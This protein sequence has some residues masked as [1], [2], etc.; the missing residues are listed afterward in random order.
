MV[1]EG[2][3]RLWGSC[4]RS[5]EAVGGCGRA[6]P[7]F[8][9]PEWFWGYTVGVHLLPVRVGLLCTP[10]SEGSRQNG[11]PSA[12]A[13]VFGPQ[14]RLPRRPA[15]QPSPNPRRPGL[16]A[17]GGVPPV[18]IVRLLEY[19]CRRC[20]QLAAWLVLGMMLIT[21]LVVFL[22]Y[23][24][25]TGSIALQESI[26]FLH[27][28]FFMLG[29]A[30]ALQQDAHVRVDIFYRRFSPLGRSLVNCAGHLFF[31]FPFCL[32]IL[33]TS[34]EYMTV[35]WAIRER[36][37]EAGGLGYV[38]L[39]KTLIPVLALSLLLQGSA[40]LIRE[41]RILRDAWRSW[42]ARG[43]RPPPAHQP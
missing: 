1:W 8:S 27:A 40:Q 3:G 11:F 20:G 29:A 34:W 21:C 26:T 10:L 39:L 35:S 23:V 12:P 41:L 9:P 14:A 17:P 2:V 31:L 32:V 42:R 36:S 33:L 15:P 6:R 13:Q 22:R 37:G 38:F 28:A 43:P 18:V 4:V 5:W 30:Y 16:G 25:Q 24:L 7:L 19:L